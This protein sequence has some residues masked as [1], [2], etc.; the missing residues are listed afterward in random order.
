[1]VKK[2][3]L[4]GLNYPDNDKLRLS[5]SYNETVY[6]MCKINELYTNYL[7]FWHGTLVDPISLENGS[8]YYAEENH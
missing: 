1:M 8:Y 4:V 3:L 5:S 2:A 7:I 6:S